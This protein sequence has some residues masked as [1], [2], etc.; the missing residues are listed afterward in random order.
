MDPVPL[1]ASCGE[2]ISHGG[3][4]TQSAVS[5]SKLWSPHPALFE[6]S[7]E[8]RPALGRLPV[9]V[10]DSH[11]LFCA[12]LPR[13]DHNKAAKAII[14]AQPHPGVD[15]V[16]PHIYVVAPGE[17]SPHELLALGLSLLSQ[18]GYRR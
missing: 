9:T 12:V 10:G 5:Y 2:D 4:E 15:A 6:V 3:P 1:M 8:L 18:T 14:A 11:Q 7:Q 13:S 17:I 16:H